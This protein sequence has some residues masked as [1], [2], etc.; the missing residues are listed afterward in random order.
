[1]FISTSYFKGEYIPLSKC[2]HL[3]KH[4]MGTKKVPGDNAQISSNP[5]DISPG[6]IAVWRN[7]N[8]TELHQ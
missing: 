6:M 3:L 7:G 5:R 4:N 8:P 2:P 1:R